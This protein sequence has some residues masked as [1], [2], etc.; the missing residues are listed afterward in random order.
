M[1]VI[2]KDA[3]LKELDKNAVTYLF[4]DATKETCY[5]SKDNIHPTVV[6]L[7]EELIN[8]VSDIEAARK[9]G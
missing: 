9:G 2:D 5:G 6:R 4:S 1:N 7:L 3:L 8:A